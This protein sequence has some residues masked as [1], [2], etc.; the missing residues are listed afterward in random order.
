MEKQSFH[1]VHT[2]IL[3]YKEEI[4]SMMYPFIAIHMLIY[5][6]CAD[7]HYFVDGF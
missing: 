1:L 4:P 2:V 7:V 6:D 3:L 5:A